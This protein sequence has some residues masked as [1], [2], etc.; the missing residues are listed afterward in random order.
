MTFQVFKDLDVLPKAHQMVLSVYKLTAKFPKEEAYGIVSQSRR[1]AVSVPTNICEGKTRGSDKDF[2]RFLF[3]ARASLTE[4]YYLIM[5]SR[6]LAYISQQE[7][8]QFVGQSDEVGRMLNSLI[9]SI[10]KDV[11]KSISHRRRIA[12]S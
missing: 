10:K 9:N 4:I 5:L 8:Q 6:D 3:I 2:L 11:L 12:K 1:A 7:Y